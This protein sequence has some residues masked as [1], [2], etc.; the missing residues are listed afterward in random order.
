[1]KTY[2]DTHRMI[3]RELTLDDEENLF[4]LD[5]DPEVMRYLTLGVP[6][7]REDI[8]AGLIRIRELHTKHNGRFGFWAAEEKQTGFFMG[9]FLFR[10][11]KD[12]PENT[13]RI[14]I[15]YRL[16][17]EFWGKGF[18]TEGS[19]EIITKGFQELMIPEIFA[20]AMKDNQASRHVIEKLGLVYI[21]E[22][23]NDRFPKETTVE[24]SIRREKWLIS[25]EPGFHK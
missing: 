3:L 19:R 5:S 9:W 6:S 13:D 24:Y 22:Y 16:R 2:R 8:R 14:E 15:G 7:S 21:R 11:A 25:R 10:P 17:K 20:I 23:P 4:A 18:A 1:M 12:S